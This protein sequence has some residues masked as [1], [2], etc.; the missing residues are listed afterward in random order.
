MRTPSVEVIVIWRLHPDAVDEL[1][2]FLLAFA[3]RHQII[4]YMFLNTEISTAKYKYHGRVAILDYPTERQIEQRPWVIQAHGIVQIPVF[5]I[6]SNNISHFES[7][8]FN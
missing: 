2:P 4:N 6:F 1:R 8:P 5:D 3:L 7:S